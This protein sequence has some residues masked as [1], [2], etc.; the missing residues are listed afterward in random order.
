MGESVKKYRPLLVVALLLSIA[1]VAKENTSDEYATA[2]ELGLMQG[3]PPPQDKRVNRSNAIIGAP[4][5]RWSYQHMRRVYPSAPIKAAASPAQL[6]RS[7]DPVIAT[8]AVKRE[9]GSISDMGTF[10][11]ETYSDALVVLHGDTVVYEH[12]A[13]GMHADQPHQMMSVTK[14]FAG[15]LAL[16]AAEKGEL[17]QDDQVTDWIPEMKRS[18][19]F[20]GASVRHVLDMT[21]SMAFSEI[22]D[23]PASDIQQYSRVIGLG[24]RLPGEVLPDNLYD[25]LLTLEKD[26]H[27]HGEA[28]VYQTPKADVVNWI[29]NRATNRSFEQD[30]HETLWARLG[31]DGETYVLLDGNGNLFAGGGLNA[32][33]NNLARFAAMMLDGG[34]FNNQQ[35]VPSAVIEQLRQ[36]GDKALFKHSADAVGVYGDGY[37]SYRAQWWVRHTPGKESFSAIG[38]N[39]QWIFIDPDRNV[40]VI[41]QSS[42]PEAY[43]AYY[44]DYT[45]NA[46]DAVV[47]HLSRDNFR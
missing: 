8:L 22:Y 7:I 14:S 34:R 21:N 47:A 40:A 44:D 15:L 9:D 16:I 17:D 31:T 19:A 29:T 28:F 10:L 45:V 37:W 12:Y 43:A 41:K 11:K 46:F 27:E 18:S 42:Q 2:A 30:M 35:V 1:A 39:G 32:T 23:D 38:I 4:H 25:Y 3:F 20:S 6:K 33:P 36:G 13:N 24:E 5:N 26:D